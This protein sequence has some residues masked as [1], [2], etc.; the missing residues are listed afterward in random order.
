[1]VAF[2]L[3]E[4]SIVKDGEV[5][6]LF[7]HFLLLL[8]F[9]GLLMF[10]L[11]LL[12]FGFSFAMLLPGFKQGFRNKPPTHLEKNVV[13]Q[14]RQNCHSTNRGTPDKQLCKNFYCILHCLQCRYDRYQK[15]ENSYS[16]CMWRIDSGGLRPFWN[17]HN[18]SSFSVSIWSYLSNIDNQQTL[19][20]Q[21]TKHKQLEI[22]CSSVEFNRPFYSYG[23]KRG[24]SGSCLYITI[25]FLFLYL[26][27]VFLC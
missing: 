1:M 15:L 16:C 20:R 5:I 8:F 21:K 27:L 24:W 7:L 26:N 3:T 2:F 9:V 4:Q 6:Y 22:H 25:R 14:P 12:F 11:W 10:F 13:F 18:R 23:W 19:K 17:I